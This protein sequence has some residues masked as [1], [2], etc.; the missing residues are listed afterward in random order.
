MLRKERVANEGSHEEVSGLGS[1]VSEHAPGLTPGSPKLTVV[2]L[3]AGAGGRIPERANASNSS[4]SSSIRGEN[5][6]YDDLE[7]DPH[8][9]KEWPCPLCHKPRHADDEMTGERQYSAE[10]ALRPTATTQSFFHL[11]EPLEGV[12]SGSDD[13][14]LLDV[15]AT[16]AAQGQTHKGQ[17]S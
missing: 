8:V 17:Y 6:S 7:L 3:G 16:S 10:A 1:E 9:C 5:R 13:D 12:K 11:H 2:S 15:V 14:L 4:T